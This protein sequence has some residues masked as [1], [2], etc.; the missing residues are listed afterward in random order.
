[1][2][3]MGMGMGNFGAGLGQFGMDGGG[4]ACQF[5]YPLYSQHEQLQFQHSMNQGRAGDGLITMLGGESRPSTSQLTMPNIYSQGGPMMGM[6]SMDI[7]PHERMGQLSQQQLQMQTMSSQ[8]N[9]G[10]DTQ[11][12]S[13]QPQAGA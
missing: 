3:G 8:N 2:P 13:N 9:D 11:P 5:Q 7:F 1:M 12:S 10:G 4:E 6:T